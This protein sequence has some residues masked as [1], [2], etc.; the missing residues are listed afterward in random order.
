MVK[1]LSL[2]QILAQ[3]IIASQRKESRKPLSKEQ[4]ESMNQS[5][6]LERALA[7]IPS[8]GNT[9]GE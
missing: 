6:P 9:S 4:L 2:D 3:A 7:E 5:T 8:A 1:P